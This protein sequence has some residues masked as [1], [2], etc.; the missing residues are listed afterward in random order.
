M[1]K[2]YNDILGVVGMLRDEG[3]PIYEGIQLQEDKKVK[4]DY[5]QHYLRNPS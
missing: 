4:V 1:N 3:N 5:Y 2:E